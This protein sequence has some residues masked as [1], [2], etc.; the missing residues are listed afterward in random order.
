M[1]NLKAVVIGAGWAGEGHTRALQSYGVNVVAICARKQEVVCEVAQRLGIPEASVDWRQTL[2]SIKPDIV[3][4][5]TPASLRREVIEEATELGCHILCDKPLAINE[6][7]AKVLWELVQQAGVKHAYAATWKYD[8]SIM[9]FSEL[10]LSG[11]IGK[12]REID[13]SYRIFRGGNLK[14]WTWWSRLETGGGLLNN[15]LPHILGILANITGGLPLRVTGEARVLRDRAP[16]VLHDIHDFRR[17]NTPTLEEAEKLE[18]RDCDSDGAFTALLSF[19]S[20][21]GV[22]IAVN[23]QGNDGIGTS[24]HPPQITLYGESGTLVLIGF[25]TNGYTVSKLCAG[26][27]EPKILPVPQRLLDGMPDSGNPVQNMW[28]ALARDFI[29]DIQGEQHRPYL[30]FY[31]GYIY[32]SAIDAIRRGNGWRKLGI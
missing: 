8:P 13:C 30:T 27:N 20:I 3:A 6:E 23:I 11:S 7:E 26:E 25:Y 16:V 15:G 31:D 28:S 2:K 1:N 32:Q 29:A 17:Q 9:W 12:I 18:W 22:E 24:V 4:I 14:P 21:S 5:A 19:S 10:A